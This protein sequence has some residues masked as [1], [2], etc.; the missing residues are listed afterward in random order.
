MREGGD[1][2]KE[3]VGLLNDKDIAYLSSYANKPLAA[4]HALSHLAAEAG[5]HPILQAQIQ[6]QLNNYVLYVSVKGCCWEG[7]RGTSKEELHTSL[8]VWG[9]NWKSE[10]APLS[11][12]TVLEA[13]VGGQM[14][15]LYPLHPHPQHVHPCNS[16]WCCKQL[17]H[18][19]PPFV[20]WLWQLS[21]K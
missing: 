16:V 19:S 1:P 12:V 15:T 5:L 14:C 18:P 21:G 2:I 17:S 3:C 11:L 10:E 13:A 9:A 4:A 8:L 20:Y 6:E 7:A